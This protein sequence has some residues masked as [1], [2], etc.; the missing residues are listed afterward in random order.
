MF[1][2]NR[3]RSESGHRLLGNPARPVRC[4]LECVESLFH[5]GVRDHRRLRDRTGTTIWGRRFD[6]WRW[7]DVSISRI[8]KWF[9]EFHKL[10]P[11]IRINYQSIGSGGGIR[12]LL[13]G[14]VDF[15]A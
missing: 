1:Q 12:Q 5:L 9:D 4:Y 6:Q 13:V 10:H 2:S 7:G 14:T 3:L 15:G 11:G 8:V